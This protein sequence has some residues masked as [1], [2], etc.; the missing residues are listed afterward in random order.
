MNLKEEIQKHNENY[1]RWLNAKT[2]IKEINSQWVEI[3]TPYLD[4]H[5]DCLQ[6]YA[7]KENDSYLLTDD[8]YIIQI[9]KI[10]DVLWKE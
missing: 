8:G 6:I 2:Q 10:V 3:T 4:R 7:K 1:Y 9:Y 5:N